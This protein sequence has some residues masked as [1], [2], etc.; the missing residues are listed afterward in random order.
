MPLQPEELQEIL[1]FDRRLT[2]L[3]VRAAIR[4]PG[5]F[6]SEAAKERCL[7]T[8]TQA[9]RHLGKRAKFLQELV[10][11]LEKKMH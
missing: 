11:A 7:Q 3:I 6:R 2:D 8:K 5:E 10:Q 9:V 4:D 1:D